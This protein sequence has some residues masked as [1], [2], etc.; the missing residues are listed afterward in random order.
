M[1]TEYVSAESRNV[2]LEMQPLVKRARIAGSWYLLL[3]ITGAF[4][5]QF[6]PSLIVNGDAA[7]TARNILASESLLRLSIL[8][9]LVETVA[10]IF[11]VLALY[12]LLKDVNRDYAS[13]MVI[14]GALVSV[15]IYFMNVLNEYAALSFLSGDS[16]LGSF[17]RSQLDSLALVFLNLH[18][19]GIAVGQIFA[20]LWLFPFGL[21]VYKSRF[22]PRILGIFLMINGF[23][24][25]GISLTSILS[26][27][28]A[29]TIDLVLFL[30]QAL[31]ELSMVA[32]LLI[33][34]VRLPKTDLKAV[35]PGISAE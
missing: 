29:T 26:L 34:G 1:N 14:L 8:S 28:F 21:L 17:S 25:L 10:S 19:Q 5:Y 3:A 31:G 24:Y 35:N 30:P 12:R 13:L 33:K 4:S 6:L 9:E 2:K 11:L 18:S 15:P 27:P 32:W 22:I 16:Y 7:A 23:A 20:G